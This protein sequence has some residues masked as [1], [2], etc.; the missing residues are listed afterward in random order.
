MAKLGK[1]Q[2]E[3]YSVSWIT[4]RLA[5]RAPEYS[6][7]RKW[8]SSVLQQV[9]N[10]IAGEIQKTLQQ[11]TEER[12]NYFPTSTNVFLL[13]K[14]Y[15]LPLGIGMDFQKE[16]RIDGVL[17]YKPPRVYA[18]IDG[19]EYEITSAQENNIETLAYNSLPSRISDAEI[20]YAYSEVVPETTIG[21]LGNITP[22][23]F[24]V[25]G[26][27]KITIDNNT[28]WDLNIGD[29]TF[30]AKVFIKGITRQ[31]TKITESIP[32]KYNGTFKTI[33][34]W[35]SIEKV[36]AS[37][38]D[39]SASITVEILEFEQNFL[40]DVKNI[41]VPNT[42]VEAFRFMRLKEESWGSALLTE[43][44]TEANIRN[45]QMGFNAKDTEYEIE[46]LNDAGDNVSLNGMTINDNFPW[47]L[48]IDDDNL[49]VYNPDLPYPDVTKL[50]PESTNTKMDLYSD[51]WNYARDETATVSTK[52]LDISTP[53]YSIRWTL[54]EP[55]GSK[56]YLGVDG[57]KWPLTTE[58]WI[59]NK[60]WDKGDW[61]EQHMDLVL[62]QKGTYILS[63]ECMYSSSVN[64]QSHYTLTTRH[65]LYT[66][67]II[68]EITLEL[69]T[70]LKESDGISFDDDGNVWL[71]KNNN[72][73]KLNLFFDYF[74]TDYL[75]KA[76]MFRENYSSVR[77][78]TQ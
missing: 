71:R 19:T 73:Q 32:I 66:P 35:D 10:P 78:V 50:T 3:R 55:N 77:V 69:P 60:G 67:S 21:N 20:S 56:W 49:Y 23:S 1:W 28:N 15:T 26:R 75:K 27:A 53:P 62:D 52:T 30:Y 24:S 41:I 42:S 29:T 44:F 64:V 74:L 70:N 14:L 63:I 12:N 7:G 37:Y 47:V 8:T 22:S 54:E 48:C 46:L 13:D 34:Q 61:K 59:D 65:L 68:P 6:H 4:Q 25:P 58:A 51:K 72:V 16:E 31:S 17:E 18:I 57:S 5:N 36:W 43:G 38:M 2:T 45:I 33:H 39:P 11:L 9:L 76:I 40:L